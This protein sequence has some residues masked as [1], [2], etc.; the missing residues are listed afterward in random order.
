MYAIEKTKR[1]IENGICVFSDA[2]RGNYTRTSSEIENM[3]SELFGKG[4]SF[5]EDKNNLIN[6]AKRVG[7]DVR[8]VSAGILL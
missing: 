8:K 6:D 1:F 7:A 4:S 3:E 5:S 2:A